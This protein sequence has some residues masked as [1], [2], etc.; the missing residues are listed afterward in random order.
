MKTE[1][2]TYRFVKTNVTACPV[3]KSI[4]RTFVAIFRVN[5]VTGEID[6]WDRTRLARG[7][8]NTWISEA[9]KKEIR[10]LAALPR[11]EDY[12]DFWL[13][14]VNTDPDFV[15]DNAQWVA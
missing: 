7:W 9:S 14:S 15:N 6:M 2:A 4:E 11:G 10:R 5:E 8:G 13:S 12:A 3:G 1:N